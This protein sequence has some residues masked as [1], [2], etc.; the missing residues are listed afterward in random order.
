[1][2]NSNAEL[3]LTYENIHQTIASH[4]THI[5]IAIIDLSFEL[6]NNIAPEQIRDSHS[7]ITTHILMNQ[8]DWPGRH[9]LSEN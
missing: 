3:P 2:R 4:N 5:S 8:P 7:G 1:L 6:S 9:E